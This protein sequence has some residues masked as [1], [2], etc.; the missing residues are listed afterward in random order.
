[1]FDPRVFEDPSPRSRTGYPRR[2]H[3][4]DDGYRATARL[5]VIVL[6]VLYLFCMAMAL[7][8]AGAAGRAD[9]PH[10]PAQLTTYGDDP[11]APA[12]PVQ[13]S[14]RQAALIYAMAWSQ[15]GLPLPDR[16][17][18]IHLTTRERLRTLLGC[19]D[20]PVRGLQLRDTIYLDRALNFADPYDASILL[21]E[22]VHYLQWAAG[23]EVS[24]CDEWA[25]RERQ[26]YAIQAHVLTMA[27]LERAHILLTARQIVC[28]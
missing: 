8:H 16:P 17:P 9:E 11:H 20:C 25:R 3:N 15:S 7:S 28:K 1:M 12:L 6:A 4:L 14:D 13:L 18:T 19:T 23:G 26:A 5:V 22:L 27:G 24:D 2:R 10:A 21:H